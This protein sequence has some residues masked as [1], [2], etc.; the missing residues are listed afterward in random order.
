MNNRTKKCVVQTLLKEPIFH[1]NLSTHKKETFLTVIQ[2]KI[3]EKDA[4]VTSL[5]ELFKKIGTF[6]S[7]MEFDPIESDTENTHKGYRLIAAV[8]LVCF[9]LNLAS[10]S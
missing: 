2:P 8:A 10:R 3:Y 7:G 4:F 6:F 5:E 1:H 9:S